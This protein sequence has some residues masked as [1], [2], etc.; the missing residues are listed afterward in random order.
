MI[1]DH[2]RRVGRS[3]KNLPGRIHRRIN[4]AALTPATAPPASAAVDGLDFTILRGVW[5][6]RRAPPFASVGAAIES[7]A[8]TDEPVSLAAPGNRHLIVDLCDA[9]RLAGNFV[10]QSAPNHPGLISMTSAPRLD[11]STFHAFRRPAPTATVECASSAHR[12]ARTGPGDHRNS[13]IHI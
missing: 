4:R 10:S 1:I 5:L 11:T 2:T 7:G 12:V 13:E 3:P 9:F 8:G 6:W